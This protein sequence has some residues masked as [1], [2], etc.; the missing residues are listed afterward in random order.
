MPKLLVQ[1]RVKLQWD[2]DVYRIVVS[3]LSCIRMTW[4][5]CETDVWASHLD[6]PVSLGW[7][8]TC[9]SN[10]FPGNAGAGRLGA[11]LGDSLV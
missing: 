4:K 1:R 6:S 2:D 9:F 10:R 8:R 7:L 11:M 3:N 5:A